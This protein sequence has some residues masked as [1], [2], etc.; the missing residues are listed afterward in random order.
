MLLGVDARCLQDPVLTGVGEYT[1]QII[2][3]INRQR[4]EVNTACWISGSKLLSPSIPATSL[5]IY[6]SSLPNKCRN[7]QQWLNIGWP[8]DREISSKIGNMDAVWLPNPSFSFLSGHLPAVLTIHD[9]S[10]LHYP[11]FFSYRGRFW[12][13][14]AVISLLRNLPQDC[15]VVTVSRHTAI[16]VAQ[17][18]PNLADRITVIP[19]AVGNEY[20]IVP[21]S[22]FVN[23]MKTDYK[24]PQKYLLSVGTIEPRKNYQLVMRAYEQLLKRNPNFEYDL[25]I[26]GSWGWRTRAIRKL[27][28]EFKYPDRIHLLG[29]VP[30]EIKPALYSAARVF[31]YPSF[32]EGY[33]MPVLEAMATGTPVIASATTSLSEVVGSDGVLVDPWQ[34]NSWVEAIENLC[35]NNQLHAELSRQGRIRAQARSWNDVGNDYL[36]LFTKITV[37]HAHRN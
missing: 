2:K 20:A 24:L 9:L 17:K 4:P 8:I 23:K 11:E 27:L 6:R 26:A 30:E 31:L 25:V 3:A 1:Y 16:D 5:R 35:T 10:F 33:G 18:F 34:P 12:Y 19:P 14:P 37:S 21:S 36:K 7:L 32:F 29:Y 22:E 28:T 13:F 15:A